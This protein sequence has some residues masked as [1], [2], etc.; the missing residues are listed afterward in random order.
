VSADNGTYIL[1]TAG[2]E[3][4]IAHASAI[5]NIYGDWSDQGHWQG[6]PHYIKQT[7]GSSRVWYNLEEAFDEAT[8]LDHTFEVSEFGVCLITDFQERK[9]FE[10]VEEQNGTESKSEEQR[11]PQSH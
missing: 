11:T 10:L 9:F 5:D 2:P 1:Q 4:R 6:S 7:F 3:F 8:I